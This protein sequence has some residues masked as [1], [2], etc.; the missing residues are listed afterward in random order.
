M[1]PMH[2]VS[3]RRREVVLAGLA[4]MVC[5]A[6]DCARGGPRAAVSD[7]LVRVVLRTA[8][9]RIDLAIDI[10]HAPLSGADF[11]RYVHQGLYADGGFYRVV[12]ADNDPSP[13]H[14]DVVQGGVMDPA[15]ALPPVAHEPTSRTGILHKNGVVSLARDE[16]GTG[17]A[18]AFFICVGD[19]PELDFGGRRQPD[20]Q[21]FAAFGRVLS[22]MQVVRRIWQMNV[23]KADVEGA[24]SGQ[25]LRPPVRF[26]SVR[27]T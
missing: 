9:G 1:P 2:A 16:V 24:M 8:V 13:V 18:A 6:S 14:I 22:G 3:V 11:L 15:K 7:R 23:A 5:L 26:H 21:G 27:R 19:Q 4:S 12:R 17:S 25:M 20:G 10:E